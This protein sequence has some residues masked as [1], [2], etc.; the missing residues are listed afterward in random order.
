MA[1]LGIAVI[2]PGYFYSHEAGAGTN[3]GKGIIYKLAG[4][5]VVQAFGEKKAPFGGKNCLGPGGPGK[6]NQ[7]QGE[8]NGC[9]NPKI[10]GLKTRCGIPGA[11]GYL[12]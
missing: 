1:L 9:W 4:E 7:Q 2:R 11:Q 12:C 10:G 6:N 5:M 3:S 8:L